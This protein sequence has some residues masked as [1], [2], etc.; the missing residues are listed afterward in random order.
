MSPEMHAS[1]FYDCSSDGV[2]SQGNSCHFFLL[3]IHNTISQDFDTSNLSSIYLLFILKCGVWNDF[4][5]S[6]N[7][8]SIYL[9]LSLFIF[10]LSSIYLY[11]SLFIFSLSS[12]YLSC[13]VVFWYDFHTSS[14][15]LYLS[16]I[17]LYLS[18]I[19]LVVWSFGMTI[20]EI[21]SLVLPYQEII[22]LDLTPHILSGLY[23][24]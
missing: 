12:S 21:I 24:E 18:S 6:S 11:L 17:Y 4:Y 20:L 8:S 2:F 15:Y 9:Y 16:Y 10:Y 23:L 1:L 22:V 19:Y 13:S 3:Q 14:L 5:T 7:L